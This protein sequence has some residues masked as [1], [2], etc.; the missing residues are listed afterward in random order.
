M[1][2]T[3][4]PPPP[5]A[6]EDTLRGRVLILV[7]PMLSK[8]S[9]PFFR[10]QLLHRNSKVCTNVSAYVQATRDFTDASLLYFFCQLH[11]R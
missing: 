10:V 4:L 8:E 2:L 3:S 9:G 5:P 7:P 11:T 1:T 6:S